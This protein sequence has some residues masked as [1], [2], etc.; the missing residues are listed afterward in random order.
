MHK[1]LPVQEHIKSNIGVQRMGVSTPATS[2]NSPILTI[3]QFMAVC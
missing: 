3:Q 2:R 1:R